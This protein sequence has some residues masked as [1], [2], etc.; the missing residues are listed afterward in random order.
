M[1]DVYLYASQAAPSD[2]VLSDPTTPIGGGPITGSATLTGTGSMIVAG[3]RTRLGAA[4]LAGN[5]S[6]SST[7]VRTRL[8]AATLA[9]AGSM[10]A[11]GVRT[12]AGASTL[13]GSGTLSASGVGTRFGAVMLAATDSLSA[14]GEVSSPASFPLAPTGGGFVSGWHRSSLGI[15]EAT[16]NKKAIALKRR[17]EEED[18][19]VLALMDFV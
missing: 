6:L 18:L 4:A 11:T 9:G 15:S 13:V 8:G 1:P 2:V 5:G 17:Q 14:S 19:M 3:V 7:G 12:L 10:T 16:L